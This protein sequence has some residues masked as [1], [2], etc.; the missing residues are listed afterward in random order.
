M[1]KYLYKGL[2]PK[3]STNITMIDSYE[4]SYQQIL[5]EFNSNLQRFI[6]LILSRNKV[7]I[8]VT[9][10]RKMARVMD[11]LQ[12]TRY[13]SI[14]KKSV[15]ISEYALCYCLDELIY[16]HNGNVEVLIIDDLINT[17]KSI[18]EVA[19]CVISYTKKKPKVLTLLNRNGNNEYDCCELLNHNKIDSNPFVDY[20]IGRN[21]EN[22]MSIGM[23][24]DME[25]PIIEIEMSKGWYMN[26]DIESILKDSF[27]LCTVYGVTHGFEYK[28]SHRTVTNYSVLFDKNKNNTYVSSDFS[29][30][31]FFVGEERLTIEIYSPRTIEDKS[32][33]REKFSQDS[34][35]QGLWNMIENNENMDVS[36][37]SN[38]FNHNKSLSEVVLLNY[39]YSFVFLTYNVNNISNV[40]KAIGIDEQCKVDARNLSLLLSPE[41][42]E[43]IAIELNSLLY[44]ENK[45]NLD[46]D[47]LIFSLED[48]E[49]SVD[50]K[51]IYEDNNTLRLHRS[52][53]VEEG[54]SAVFHN[55]A[56]LLLKGK[57]AYESFAS[58]INK[59]SLHIKSEDML[60]ET[61]KCIDFM[62]DDASVTPAYVEK[63]K[64]GH[65]YWKRMFSSGDN[66][67]LI[68]KLSCIIKYI[69]ETYV[70]VSHKSAVETTE[71]STVLS[72]VL[73]NCLCDIFEK[74]SGKL[75]IQHNVMYSYP[76][77]NNADS[78]NILR[79]VINIGYID[80]VNVDGLK[81]Y[82]VASNDISFIE[83]LLYDKEKQYIEDLLYFIWKYSKHEIFNLR[84]VMLDLKDEHYKGIADKT[85]IYILDYIKDL[86]N[87]INNKS[88]V[89]EFLYKVA[90]VL[91]SIQQANYFIL[92][93]ELLPLD[94]NESN[95]V[96]DIWVNIFNKC[97]DIFEAEHIELSSKI[98]VVLLLTM[99]IID[100]FFLNDLNAAEEAFRLIKTVGF[101]IESFSNLFSSNNN[102]IELSTVLNIY[103]ETMNGCWKR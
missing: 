38:T 4:N 65:L 29:K 21:V 51:Q 87:K 47:N 42:A 18:Q 78:I 71:F 72:M 54:I 45:L 8:I 59:L 26:H 96:K 17:G 23:P 15:V 67:L 64:G 58:I 3:L 53:T 90:N 48:N 98:D 16:K 61:H 93:N 11:W 70:K 89:S 30:I 73:N 82:Q 5:K 94:N 80:V 100:K 66:T 10:S 7:P 49:V 34:L 33:V 60:E 24:L 40:L 74:N 76:V 41:K 1:Q 35:L 19:T 68:D 79:Y 52:I 86:P 91:I 103:I 99:S 63:R 97:P 6:S 85:Y 25:F 56:K 88:S 83:P 43:K 57:Y 101:E 55:Q 92:K 39:L 62:I 27:P 77:F 31:R 13:I 46:Y 50:Y 9:M 20:C 84:Y 12:E 95:T 22:I 32:N 2:C 81:C 37:R 102:K 36:N 44:S 28:D 75:S 69:F 14:P